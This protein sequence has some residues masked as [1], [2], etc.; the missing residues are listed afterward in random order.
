MPSIE[1]LA[2]SIDGRIGELKGEIASLEDARAALVS[3]GLPQ[4]PTRKGRASRTVRRK[5][6]PWTGRRKRTTRKEVLPAE[7]A[8]QLLADNDGLTTAAL[9]SRAGADRNQVL[10]LL[11]DLETARRVRRTGDRRGTRWHAITDEDRIQERAGELASRSRR[12]GK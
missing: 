6:A 1:Q 11:R 3:N 10:T 8:E 2:Q 5:P 4:T 9:A 12:R 7:T